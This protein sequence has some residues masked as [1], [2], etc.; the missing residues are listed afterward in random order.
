[1]TDVWDFKHPLWCS[2]FLCFS[3]MVHGIGWWLVTDVLGQHINP[4]FKDQAVQEALDCLALE[5]GTMG[6]LETSV[7]NYH[8]ILCNSS[9]ECRSHLFHGRS[10]ESCVCFFFSLP[11]ELL[12]LCVW[13]C[14][15][16]RLV[17]S[18]ADICYVDVSEM[19]WLTWFSG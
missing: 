4:L 1:M 15:A 14:E 5:D 8:C 16:G 3:G 11:R 19:E 13:G 12:G 10:L 17:A 2:W 7:R 9:E 6:C 18:G